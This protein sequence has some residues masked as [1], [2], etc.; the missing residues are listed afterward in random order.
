MLATSPV[1]TG[2][3]PVTKTIG[4]LEVAAFTANVGAL[5]PVM[6]TAH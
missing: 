6:I 5:P 1:F 4:T 2:S 3:S